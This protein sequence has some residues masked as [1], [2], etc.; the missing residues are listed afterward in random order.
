MLFNTG[1]CHRKLKNYSEGIRYFTLSLA[2]KPQNAL[3][4]TAIGL[5]HHLGGSLDKAVE[6]YHQSLGLKPDDAF[7][8]D[9]LKRALD[10]F[11]LF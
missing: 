8:N 4:L 7:T 11:Q 10:D 6:F 9:M 2:L 3:A 5:S 1:H